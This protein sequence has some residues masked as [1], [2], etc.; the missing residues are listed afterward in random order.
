MKLADVNLSPVETTL[1]SL[2]EQAPT[3]PGRRADPRHLTL[4]RVGTILLDGVRELC[5][6]KNISAGGLMLRVYRPVPV[7]QQLQVELKSGEPL[8]GTA[9]WV[10]GPQIGVTLDEPIDVIAILSNSMTGPRPRMPRIE[11]RSFVQVRDGA[12]LVRARACDI[13]QGG[14]K[15]E[16]STILAVGT[17]VVVL[18][19]KLAPQPGIVRWVNG[20]SVG[21]TFNS[22]VPLPVLVEWL[23]G[24]R[25]VAKAA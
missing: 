15:I 19:P 9:T 2:S 12:N 5:L 11:T 1:Y 23:Q 20:N 4:Y 6:I 25:A 7:G 13:S 22:L 3:P 18:L 14:L 16:S 10:L 8:S 21:L 24:Q 17:E